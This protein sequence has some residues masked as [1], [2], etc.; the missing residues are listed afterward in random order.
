[1]MHHTESGF[2]NPEIGSRNVGF[3]D[4]IRWRMER[5]KIRPTYES[6]LNT[7][8]VVQPDWKN[9]YKPPNDSQMVTWIGHATL[10]VQFDGMNIL[11]DPI[12]SDRCSPAQFIGPK[13]YTPLSITTEQLPTIHVVLLSH[14]HYDSLDEHT[15]IALG[16]DP[17]WFVPLGLKKWFK[18]QGITN[19]IELDW[20]SEYEY[21][22]FK[23]VS[24]P[25]QHFSGR[26]LF[27]RNKTLWCSWVVLG[28]KHR[29]WF[30][31]DTGYFSEFKKIGE[32]YGPFDLAAIPIGAYNPEWFMLPMHL[33]PQQAVHVHQDIGSKQSIAIHWGTFI[34]TDEPVDEPPRLLRIAMQEIGSNQESFTV[35]KH[36]ET[37]IYP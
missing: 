20:W 28:K 22:G 37:I 19:V 31:G 13:R 1:M 30:A 26:G 34:L 21:K 17:I 2:S 4:F 36:G 25:T 24:T 35:L 9:I 11:T 8:P 3:K 32:K 6:A 5:S 14:N 7:F 18:S 15:V 12:F 16:N 33:N 10:L 29:F 27:D 23:F